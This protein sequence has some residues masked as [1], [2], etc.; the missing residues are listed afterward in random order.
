MIPI[1]FICARGDS[2]P[3]ISSILVIGKPMHSEIR[4][5]PPGVAKAE[6][7]P[8]CGTA[9]REYRLSREY[10]QAWRYSGRML[11]FFF[12]GAFVGFAAGL[13]MFGP[14]PGC[15]FFVAIDVV[16]F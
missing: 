11:G 4:Q 1:D 2:I 8:P 5:T 7:Q 16:P 6:W 9:M 15:F 3:Q 12:T 14:F 10:H 13:R